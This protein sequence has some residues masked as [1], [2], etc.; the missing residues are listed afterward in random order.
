[1]TTKPPSTSPREQQNEKQSDRRGAQKRVPLVDGSLERCG[2]G[3]DIRVSSRLGRMNGDSPA[4]AADCPDGMN[5]LFHEQ[6]SVRSGD[7]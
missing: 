7:D 3:H 4:C 6:H 1:M 5:T 2:Y